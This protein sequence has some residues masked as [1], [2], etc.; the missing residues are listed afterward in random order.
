[1]ES[2]TSPVDPDMFPLQDIEL[3]AVS[4]GAADEFATSHRFSIEI[5]GVRIGGV[6]NVEGLA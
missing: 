2:V 6:H 4:G 5:D 3:D 1:M